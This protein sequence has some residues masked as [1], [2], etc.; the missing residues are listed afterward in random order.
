MRVSTNVYDLVK[1]QKSVQPQNKKDDFSSK[2]SDLI[3]TAKQEVKNSSNLYEDNLTKIKDEIKDLLKENGLIDEDDT[4][5]DETKVLEFIQNYLGGQ[6]HINAPDVL[7]NIKLD[8]VPSVNL[9]IT[10]SITPLIIV[11]DDS[12]VI[13]NNN[14][15]VN[16]QGIENIKALQNSVTIDME[17]K[18]PKSTFV[19][20]D[21]VSSTTVNQVSND[22]V[23]HPVL[24]NEQISVHE[25][26]NGQSNNEQVSNVNE[27]YKNSSIDIKL[28]S[29]NTNVS[30]NTEVVQLNIV[31][32]VPVVE[33]LEEFKITN[34]EKA[35]LKDVTVS[36][37]IIKNDVPELDSIK[38]GDITKQNEVLPKETISDMTAKI[39]T[40]I[41]DGIKEFNI[42]L[43]PKELGEISVKIA[44]EMSKISVLVSCE[45]SKTQNLMLSSKGD[46]RSIIE[47]NFASEVVVQVEEQ[48]QRQ[49]YTK[50]ESQN[51]NSENRQPKQQKNKSDDGQAFLQQL[52]LGL[53]K[54][55][56]L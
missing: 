37:Q 41:K 27:L 31:D 25:V 47:N 18:E 11:P 26:I 9:D 45:N 6:T 55:D 32:E 20:S 44:F 53:V 50:Q 1:N 3:K 10:Q 30:V 22:L 33:V 12:N 8:L 28:A 34:D 40:N 56:N 38:V 51:D 7:E 52:R 13:I 4:I 17:L 24:S 5:T 43:N 21:V 48:D 2:F 15:I 36:N 29:T 16:N 39:M 54:L 49:D 23:L 19:A 46:L 35:S 14:S 42:V